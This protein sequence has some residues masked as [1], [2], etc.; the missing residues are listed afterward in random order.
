MLWL[1]ALWLVPITAFLW[2]RRF[3]STKL[4]QITGF[5]FGA[6]V[7]PAAMGLYGLFFLGPIPGLIGMF[8]GLP[9]TLL[10][11]GPGYNLAIWLGLIQPRTVVEGVQHLYTNLLS[12]IFWLAVYGTLGWIVDWFRA[13]RK[14]KGH[15]VQNPEDV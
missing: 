6:V 9:L 4:W 10:H 7:S 15:R 13:R 1:I 2:A 8:V 14:S 12:G 3:F 5:A 11:G